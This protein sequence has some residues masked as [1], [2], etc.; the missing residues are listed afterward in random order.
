MFLTKF[1]GEVLNY[2]AKFSSGVQYKPIPVRVQTYAT[3]I[4]VHTHT[5]TQTCTNNWR[6]I[7]QYGA[8]PGIPLGCAKQIT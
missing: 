6:I 1:G 4:H 5:H 3:Y 2:E 8:I 7:S